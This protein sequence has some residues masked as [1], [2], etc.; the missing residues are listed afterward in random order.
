M[1]PDGKTPGRTAV[2]TSSAPAHAPLSHKTTFIKHKFQG[3]IIRNFK[4]MAMG[5]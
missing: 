3:G 2:Q 5:R 4:M 1:G